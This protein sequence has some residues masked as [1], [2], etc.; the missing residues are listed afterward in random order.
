MFNWRNVIK[1][2]M[3][4]GF[5]ASASAQIGFVSEHSVDPVGDP[6]DSAVGHV[7]TLGSIFNGR[8]EYR[9]D[10]VIGLF[11]SQVLPL[12]SVVDGVSF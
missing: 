1:V 10:D 2:R 7:Y 4:Y 12:Y 9:L 11:V 5:A 8:M 6:L 3:V